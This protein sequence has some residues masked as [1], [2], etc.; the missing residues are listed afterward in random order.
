MIFVE[1]FDSLYWTFDDFD[2]PVKTIKF[3]YKSRQIPL[4]KF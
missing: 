4:N 3:S 1:K 2:F